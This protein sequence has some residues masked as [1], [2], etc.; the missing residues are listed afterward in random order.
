[1]ANPTVGYKGTFTVGASTVGKTKD[2][3][4]SIQATEI[5]VTSRD[6]AGFNENIHGILKATFNNTQVWIPTDVA[7]AAMETALFGR[8]VLV[9]VIEDENGYGWSGNVKIYSIERGEPLDD[10]VMVTINGSFTG[11]LTQETGTV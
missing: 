6:S 7:Y 11:T 5:D 1:M 9:A 4:T 2:L 3:T 8:T 10:G